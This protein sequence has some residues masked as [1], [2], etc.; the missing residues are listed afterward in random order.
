MFS[1]CLILSG[2]NYARAQDSGNGVLV[3]FQIDESSAV[4]SG[5][6]VVQ[7]QSGLQLLELT[8]DFGTLTVADAFVDAS[9]E[10]IAIGVPTSDLNSFGEI[11][12]LLW[13]ETPNGSEL[14]DS[15]IIIVP[16]ENDWDDETDDI[17][18]RREE[19]AA[20][21]VGGTVDNTQIICRPHG[22]TDID[23]KVDGQPPS[24]ISVGGPSKGND[25]PG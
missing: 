18:K 15:F 25:L 7:N 2:H 10:V 19:K 24:Y 21:I 12:A 17:G 1:F 4:F 9:G 5:F 3:Q 11:V 6:S 23:V 16:D 8:D 20:G 13:V 14:A 22:T